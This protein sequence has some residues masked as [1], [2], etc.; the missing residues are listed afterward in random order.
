MIGIR[1]IIEDTEE[2]C[3]IEKQIIS[4]KESQDIIIYYK[5]EKVH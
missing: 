2:L 5:I 4:K 1:F 3:Y